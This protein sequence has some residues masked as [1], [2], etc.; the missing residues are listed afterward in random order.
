MVVSPAE[1]FSTTFG[2]LSTQKPLLPRSARHP[3]VPS[4]TYPVPTIAT[5]IDP[6]PSMPYRKLSYDTSLSEFPEYSF[7]RYRLG[8]IFRSLDIRLPS[9]VLRFPGFRLNS[10]RQ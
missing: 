4:P 8:R 6:L 7:R 1:S 3:P 2:L 9:R 5:F 10:Y